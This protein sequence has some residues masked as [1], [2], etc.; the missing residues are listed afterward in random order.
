[1]PDAEPTATD[2]QGRFS[3]RGIGPKWTV[4]IQ[5]EHEQFARQELDIKP[6]DRARIFE[7]MGVKSAV[8]LASLLA[9]RE[10]LRER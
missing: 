8:E 4:T 3:L 9:S 1:M 7:E 5:T 6:E 10:R 2:A